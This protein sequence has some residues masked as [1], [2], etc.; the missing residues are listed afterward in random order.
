M[1]HFQHVDRRPQLFTTLRYLVVCRSADVTMQISLNYD[2]D[3]VDNSCDVIKSSD[4]VFFDGD[5]HVILSPLVLLPPTTTPAAS[6]SPADCCGQ[7]PVHAVRLVAVPVRVVH[8]E[9]NADD[10]TI[11][12]PS[13]RVLFDLRPLPLPPSSSSS[14]FYAPSDDDVIS[15]A[16]SQPLVIQ[17]QPSQPLD[18]MQIQ[19]TDESCSAFFSEDETAFTTRPLTPDIRSERCLSPPS[20]LRPNN[21]AI[22]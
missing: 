15:C 13:R 12:S 2:Q 9:T 20:G 8:P 11:G 3:D 7:A 5:D 10:V 22:W 18:L 21:S 6:V 17:C 1:K 16:T 19:P 4:D 14:W